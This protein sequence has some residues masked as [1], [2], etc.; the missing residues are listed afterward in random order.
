MQIF[1]KTLTGRTLAQEVEPTTFINEA[2]AQIAAAEGIPA[3]QQIMIAA[4]E[5]LD[6]SCTFADYNIEDEAIVNFVVDM[7]GGGKKRKK[8]K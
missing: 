8:K 7:C 6:D 3:D 5:E 2:K 4:G 1:F